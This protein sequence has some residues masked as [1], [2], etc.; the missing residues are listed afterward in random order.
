MFLKNITDTDYKVT[1]NY[2]KNTRAG[3]QD[4][5][6]Q[7]RRTE[8]ELHEER[9]RKYKTK[10][11]RTRTE[12]SDEDSIE[13]T[14][15]KQKRNKARRTTSTDS[16]DNTKFEGELN[17]TEKGLLRFNGECWKKMD[18]KEKEFVRDYNASV[19]HGE[20]DKIVIPSGVTIKK[21]IRRTLSEKSS[22]LSEPSGS[23]KALDK[24]KKGVS[25]NLSN[26]DHTAQDEE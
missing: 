16:S 4:C 6:E 21:K 13:P 12:D 1:V 8:I 9:I 11:R 3:L 26:D 2:C 5:V 22:H 25:F 19:K 14:Q 7:V 20:T 23:K 15:K 24:R 10:S 17:T 18:E